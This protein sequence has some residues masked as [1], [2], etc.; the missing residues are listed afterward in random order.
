LIVGDAESGVNQRLNDIHN[1]DDLT[2]NVILY[3]LHM[4]YKSF[5]NVTAELFENGR[6]NRRKP[7]LPRY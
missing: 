7:H 1:S 6:S 4:E 3:A 5:Q 2:N